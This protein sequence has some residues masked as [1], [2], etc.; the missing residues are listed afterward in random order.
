MLP[1]EKHQRAATYSTFAISW[2]AN[3]VECLL[4]PLPY[5]IGG[6]RRQPGG[7]QRHGGNLGSDAGKTR[8]H[9]GGGQQPFDRL[10]NRQ[11]V[12]WGG[13]P[14]GPHL[15]GRGAQETGGTARPGG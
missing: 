1:R 12:P 11:G 15:P 9:H 2:A 8:P 13:R 4:A 14:T 3:K 10:G 6:R 5:A 7:N